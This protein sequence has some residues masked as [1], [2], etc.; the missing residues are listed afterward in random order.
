MSTGTSVFS[1]PG[2]HRALP[3]TDSASII[4]AENPDAHP[5]ET[6]RLQRSL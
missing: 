2:G 6:V 4:G 1:G 5:P 3:Y